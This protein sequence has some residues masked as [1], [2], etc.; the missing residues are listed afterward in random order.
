MMRLACLTASLAATLCAAPRFQ[1]RDTQGRLHTHAELASRSATVFLFLAS[2]CPLSNQY[3]PRLNELH[4]RYAARGIGFLGVHADPLLNPR[5]AADHTTSFNIRFPVLLDPGQTLTAQL[6]A[7]VTPQAILMDDSGNILYRGRIDDRSPRLGARRPSPSRHDLERAIQARLNAQPVPVP[8]TRPTGCAIPKPP[9]PSGKVT[10]TRD[11]APILF[12]HCASCHRPGHSGPFPLL[13]FRDAAS[14]A[15]TIAQV[16]AARIM[17]P[18]LP[19]EGPPHFQDERRLNPKE[20]ATLRDWAA[21]GA[22]QGDPAHLPQLPAFRDGWLLG[23]PDLIVHMPRPFEIPAAGPDQYRCFVLPLKVPEDRW[24]RAVEFH[25][26]NRAIVHHSLIFADASSAARRRDAEDPGDG[27]RCF[28]V[29]GFL[30][31]ASYGGWTPGMDPRPYPDGVAFRLHRNADIVL[32]VHYHSTGKPETDQSSLGLYFTNEEPTRRVMDV[33]LGSRAIDIPA[34]ESSYI[35]RDHFTLP[36]G[37][38]AVG[39]IPHAHYLCRRMRAVA[40]LPD[41]RSLTLIDIPDWDFN[42]QQNYRYRRPF[43]LP[44]GTL[45]EMEFT[46]D[47]SAANPRNPSTPPVRVLYGPDS[48]D[49]MAGLHLQVIPANNDDAAELGRSLW[50]KIMR[51][52]GGRIR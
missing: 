30:P 28:G 4:L 3:I 41:G 34:G 47:N 16:T 32:Q 5:Q 44:A 40:S 18:W 35:V 49:E 10:F 6:G 13:T 25:P 9:A 24:V 38:L 14:R 36:V 8:E 29:P 51:E 15:E 7:S 11:V 42:W 2:E 21:Q 19:A 31:S 48:T 12:R 50:G 26:G 17:P 45:L 27:Y 20:I 39:I 43:T 33:A 37:V 46:Y 23:A 1:L 22:P 52:L